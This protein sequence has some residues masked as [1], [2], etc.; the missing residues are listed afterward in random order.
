MLISNVKL[1]CKE[2]AGFH[3]LRQ[4]RNTQ[5]GFL[6]KTTNV[7]PDNILNEVDDAHLKEELRSCQLFIVECVLERARHK[8][9]NYAVQNL[10]GTVVN[11]KL[12]H[13]FGNL[14]CAAKVNVAFG[15]I[16]KNIDGG[17]FK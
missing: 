9:F 5:N 13:F 7:Q 1:C 16:L 3:A 15:F 4:H 12:D 8:I 6:I 11:G 10:N 17:G 2:L 14:K